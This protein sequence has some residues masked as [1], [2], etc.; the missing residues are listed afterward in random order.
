MHFQT[1]ATWSKI[2]QPLRLAGNANI[3]KMKITNQQQQLKLNSRNYLNI[4]PAKSTFSFA[5]LGRKVVP[6]SSSPIAL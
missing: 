3:S 4:L 2:L 5:L 6:I 1:S